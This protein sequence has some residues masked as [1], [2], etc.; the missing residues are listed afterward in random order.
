MLKALE[1]GYDIINGRRNFSHYPRSRRIVSKLYNKIA[2][3]FVGYTGHDL[4]C[5]IKVFRR[6][7]VQETKLRPGYHRYMVALAERNGFNV[8]EVDV[9]LSPRPRGGSNYSTGRILEGIIDLIGLRIRLSF[10][11]RPMFLFG[12]SGLV[13]STIGLLI[14]AYLGYLAFLGQPITL[15]PLTLISVFLFVTGIQ[16]LSLGLLSEMLS[17]LREEVKSLRDNLKST[18]EAS[19]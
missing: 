19:S 13:L 8:G 3:R 12:T 1:Q 6:E 15:R 4:N 10:E 18:S 14:G 9:E 11:E 7:V 16:F 17:G 5:G 2:R